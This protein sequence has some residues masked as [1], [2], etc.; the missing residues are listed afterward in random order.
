[1]KYLFCLVF[2]IIAGIPLMAQEDVP[3]LGIQFKPIL[4]SDI[5]G[6]GP[7]EV[8][9]GEINF[10]VN[11]RNGYSFGML[12]RQQ[13]TDQIALESG[14]SYTKRNFDLSIRNDTTGFTGES[15][16]RYIIYEIPI[17][18]LVYVQVGQNAYLSNALGLS[19]NFLPS[20]WESFDTYFTHFSNRQ[21][22]IVPSL[23]ANVGAEFRTRESGIIYAGLSFHLPFTNFTRAGI[24]YREGD[25]ELEST[26]FDMSGNYLTIDLRYYFHEDPAWKQ[27]RERQ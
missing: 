7:Q 2:I 14:I 12:I 10:R 4:S 1:M 11:P 6:T 19:I 23:L 17:T 25:L 18:A 24:G 8:Q 27:K 15:D 5:I 16:F 22:W 20:D 26:S 3:T 9:S 21:S 13:I